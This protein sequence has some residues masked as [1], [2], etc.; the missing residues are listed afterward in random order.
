MRSWICATHGITI[1]E[2]AGRREVETPPGSIK[3]MPPC[4]ILTMMEP[5]EG[6]V[7]QCQIKEC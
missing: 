7:G 5:A 2:G 4:K 3:G 6:Q 1:R